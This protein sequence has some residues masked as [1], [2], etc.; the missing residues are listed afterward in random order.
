M[1]NVL[2][3]ADGGI[4]KRFSYD[5]LT[6]RTT[7][8]AT[9]DVNAILERNKARQNDGPNM[10]RDKSLKHIASIPNI[11]VMKWIQEDGINF[12]RL[13]KHE[14]RKYLKRKLNDPDYRHLRTG[15]GAY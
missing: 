8:S 13:P 6:D 14:A 10:T 2:L 11:F 5:D 9:Q 4:V 7:I 1:N 3:D 12:L 15:L